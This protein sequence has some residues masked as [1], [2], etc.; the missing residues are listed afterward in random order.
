MAMVWPLPAVGKLYAVWNC[1]GQRESPKA[2]GPGQT[3]RWPAA[4]AAADSNHMAGTTRTNIWSSEGWA[5]ERGAFCWGI[6]YYEIAQSA[7]G[8][9]RARAILGNQAVI[10]S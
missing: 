1:A 3:G 5:L 6:S 4:I 7:C 10:T 8:I 9:C 2:A